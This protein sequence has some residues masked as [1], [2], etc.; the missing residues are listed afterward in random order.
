MPKKKFSVY[1]ELCPSRNV[2]EKISDK[3]SILIITILLNKTYRFGEL[4]REIGGI[5]PKMLTQTLIKLERLGFIVRQ[6][7]PVLPMKVEYSL[8]P[9]GGE[10][11]VILSSLTAW[12]EK[13]MTTI[14][15][16]ENKFVATYNL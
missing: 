16:A 14:M 15:F 4:K 7:F 6:S 3:W 13:N 1:Q 10:L 12:T 9:L 5:S 11:G 8:T 2:L